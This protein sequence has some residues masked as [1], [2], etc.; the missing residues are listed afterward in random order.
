M[1]ARGGGACGS[2]AGCAGLGA[3]VGALRSLGRLRSLAGSLGFSEEW[4][5]GRD[6]HSLH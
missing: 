1:Q 5:A 4:Q 3:W 6:I 2:G